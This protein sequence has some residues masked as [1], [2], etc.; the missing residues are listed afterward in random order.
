LPVRVGPYGAPFTRDSRLLITASANDPVIIW[1]VATASELER[2]PGLGTN[3]HSV[4]L[5]PDERLLAVGSLDGTIRIWDLTGQRLVKEFRPQSL[6]I[7][8]LRFW[9]GGKTL[10]SHAMVWNR[11]IAVQ[12]WDVASWVEIPFG[13][14]DVSDSLALAQSPDQRLLAVPSGTGVKLW[15]Y[16]TGELQA[17]FPAE[18]G[19]TLT[20]FSPDSRFLAAAISDGA[21]VWEVRSGRE[22][23]R[24]SLH[25]NQVISVTFSPDDQ[26]LVTGGQVGMDLQ[27]AL[28]VWDYTL[29]RQLL[30]LPS[31]GGFKGWTEFSPDGNTLL[32]L[33]WS[34]VA[35]LY[36]APSWEEIETEEKGEKAP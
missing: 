5:S 9:D 35:D 16:A 26:R 6:P 18:S 11:Q 22:V 34:G 27:P 4:A 12:R 19:A 15:E 1:D 30:S 28:V 23:A 3:N 8:G 36:R 32:G 13:R 24:L 14:L 25:A 20:S 21:R 17:V 33:S 10:A 31:D 7:F 29:Q 2:L